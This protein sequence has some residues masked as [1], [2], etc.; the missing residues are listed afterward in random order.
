[1][2]MDSPEDCG[3]CMGRIEGVIQ[4]PDGKIRSATAVSVGVFR[5]KA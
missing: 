3:E 2:M 5:A 1:M 4:G